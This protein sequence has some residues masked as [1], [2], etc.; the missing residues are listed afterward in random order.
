M[1]RGRQLRRPFVFDLSHVGT[2]SSDILGIRIWPKADIALCTAM[3]AFRGKADMTY[4]GANVGDASLISFKKG[5][6]LNLIGGLPAPARYH[7][8]CCCFGSVAA[9]G[10]GA[11]GNN[12]AG[13]RA[14]GVRRKRSEVAF[15][16][17]GV[18]NCIA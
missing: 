2:A 12:E 15:A 10:A 7:Q 6:V 11:A 13:R 18:P 8:S 16:L 5:V 4:C 17:R 9:C 3:S 14:D 1:D